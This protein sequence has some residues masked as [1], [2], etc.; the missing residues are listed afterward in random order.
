MLYFMLYFICVLCNSPMNI[1]WILDFKLLLLLLLL[2][3]L[4]ANVYFDIKCVMTQ[5]TAVFVE[6]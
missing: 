1:L 4:F 2:L 3:L 6:N 5:H